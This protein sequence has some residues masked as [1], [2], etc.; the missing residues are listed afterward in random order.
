MKQ[1]IGCDTHLR[2]SVFRILSE[3]GVMGP[4][5][6]VEHADGEIE[7]FLL[8]SGTLPEVGASRRRKKLETLS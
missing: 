8:R 4:A 2:Y 6:R 5:I 1:Y 3:D 7:R